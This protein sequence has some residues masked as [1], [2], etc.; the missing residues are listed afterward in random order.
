MSLIKSYT[1]EELD[2][3]K[4]AQHTFTIALSE[5]TGQD[6]SELKYYSQQVAFL[7]SAFEFES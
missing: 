1:K 2:A 7:V 3:R 5:Y 4:V 6:V